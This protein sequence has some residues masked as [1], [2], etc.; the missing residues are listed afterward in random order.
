MAAS[1]SPEE[2]DRRESIRGMTSS[3]DDSTLLDQRAVLDALSRAVVVTSPD[4]YILL[5]NGTAELLYGSLEH[6]VVGR[7]ILDV[8]APPAE[9]ATTPS[10]FDVVAGG[11]S[12]AGDRLIQ[13]RDG[14]TIRVRTHT[15]PIVGPD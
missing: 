5:W 11:I 2:S 14:A 9:L 15:A 1:A 8:L 7:S 4:G 13:R 10:D 12:M 6:E 3:G